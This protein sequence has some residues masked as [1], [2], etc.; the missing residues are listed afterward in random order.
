MKKFTLQ[1]AGL[2]VL[3]CWAAP[4][5]NAQNNGSGNGEVVIIQKIENED[6]SVT[7]VKK[8]I[9]K[10]E[11]VKS[12]VKQF[13]DIDGNVEIHVLSDGAQMEAPKAED[14]E[15]IFL[16][17]RGKESAPEMD[18]QDMHRELENMKIIIHDDNLKDYN[19][20]FNWNDSEGLHQGENSRLRAEQDVKAFLGVYPGQTDDGIGVKLN[21]VVSGS[22]AEA[23]GLQKGDV[24]TAIGGQA[25]NGDYGLRGV[26]SKLQPGETVSVQLLRAGQPMDVQ[27][28]L[29][30][31]EYTR[32]VLND[33]RNPCK[34]FIGVY[35]GGKASE[36]RGVQVTGI[37]G[38]TPAEE[39][40]LE[41]GDVILAMDGVAVNDNDELLAERDKHQP[42]QEFR[43][44]ILRNGQEM[45]L[46]TRFRIC[47]NEE[48]LKEEV[49]VEE[50]VEPQVPALEVPDNELQLA[51][52]KAFPNPAFS[53]VTIQFQAEA[54]PTVI[55][56]A[57]ASGRVVL[58]RQLNNFDGSFKEELD[59]RGVT[60][61]ALTLTIRQG[62]KLVAKQL[63]LLNRA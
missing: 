43:L 22:G 60:P 41:S 44:T 45:Q 63:V 34:V 16:F 17:R 59:L 15:T 13:E 30:E 57:D 55:Q 56:L 47:T 58:Q 50:P 39:V 6:G 27:V 52:Y 61:G 18:M 7:T 11:D 23:G 28:T 24:V 9:Q 32:W 42:G 48:P 36:G 10:G 46:D 3:L 5:L 26:L 38:N 29:G 14:G 35:V 62:D 8:R 53:F 33:E 54:V 49:I 37:I 1:L 21:G 19:F 2:F 51:E 25:T 12:I 31:K 20:N 4:G 40:G